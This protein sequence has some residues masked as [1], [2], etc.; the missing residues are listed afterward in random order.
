MS[1]TR[2]LGYGRQ[3]IDD[4]DVSAVV[5]VLREDYL[6]QGPVVERFERALAERVGAQYAVAVSSG[7][8]ALHIACIASG[9]KSGQSGFTSALTFIASVNAMI[10]C[11]AKAGLTD[12]DPDALG[13]S[14]DTLSK[15]LERNPDCELVIPVHFAGLAH[16]S[17]ELRRVAGKRTV[18]EDACHALGG[19]YDDGKSIGSCAYADM[20]TFSFHPVKS[21]TTTEGGAVTTN[22]EAT[23]RTLLM[24]RNHGI[25]RDSES[26]ENTA[27]AKD[28]DGSPAPWYYE[29]QMLGY[30]YRMSDL[31]AALGLS[32]LTKLDFFIARRREIAMRYD[33]A[34]ASANHVRLPQS[35]SGHRARSAHH[36]YTVNI[37]YLALGITRVT[38]ME[39]LRE[40]GIGSQVHYVPIYHQPYHHKRNIGEAREFPATEAH[41]RE[42]LSLPIHAGLTDEEAERVITA[43]NQVLG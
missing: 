30:N 13:M 9:L 35:T 18:I 41:Y 11:G 33:E 31:Q 36:L 42:C 32:Q 17:A 3:L 1:K 5:S 14:G 25:E 2:F 34:F 37:D 21:I 28:T 16:D 6:T 23:Y 8:A 12:I 38:V 4:A 29:Q 19:T 27:A 15:A 40:S 20:A 26:L 10:Y 7:T 39:R 22:D 43:F 24:L